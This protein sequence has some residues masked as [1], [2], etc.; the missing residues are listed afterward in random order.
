MS[1]AQF[2]ASAGSGSVP[3]V[4]VPG[5]TVLVIYELFVCLFFE[6]LYLLSLVLLAL[7]Y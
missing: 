4:L 7:V 6:N 5:F 2:C 1:L 3:V